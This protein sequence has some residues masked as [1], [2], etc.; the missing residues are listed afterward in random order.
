LALRLRFFG[1]WWFV[2]CEHAVTKTV[3][4]ELHDT[5]DLHQS[6]SENHEEWKDGRGT[7]TEILCFH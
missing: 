7:D 5:A 4:K 1:K 6:S 2:R 3:Q